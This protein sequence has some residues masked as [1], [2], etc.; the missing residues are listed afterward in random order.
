MYA[1]NISNVKQNM[2]FQK[3]SLQKVEAI[4][5]VIRNYLIV[6]S[7]G[8][9]VVFEVAFNE[10]SKIMLKFAINWRPYKSYFL[11]EVV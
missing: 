6:L 11:R 7:Q 1:S 4:Y 9:I 8:N 3:F 2:V 10:E 5:P